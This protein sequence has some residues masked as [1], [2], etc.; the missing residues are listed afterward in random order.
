MSAPG[1][2]WTLP[3]RRKLLVNSRAAFSP[4]QVID[5]TGCDDGTRTL[6]A[7]NRGLLL[8]GASALNFWGPGAL[9]VW[10][11]L[12]S[13]ILLHMRVAASSS[14]QL[15]VP[16]SASCRVKPL[17]RLGTHHMGL[18]RGDLSSQVRRVAAAPEEIPE[19]SPQGTNQRQV[20]WSPAR[21]GFAPKLYAASS[22]QPAARQRQDRGI[23]H[24]A[25]G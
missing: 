23:H 16:R 19:F 17:L 20:A 22:L 9:P 21:I 12:S 4:P 8:L 7:G 10:Q 24:I 13:C 6:I 3:S 15:L 2:V 14:P 1:L 5:A 18:L 11:A 25:Y